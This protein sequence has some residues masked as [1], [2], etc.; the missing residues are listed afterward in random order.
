MNECKTLWN[1]LQT[2]LI[3]NISEDKPL[4]IKKTLQNPE[5]GQDL[6]LMW[7]WSNI[8]QDRDFNL[9]LYIASFSLH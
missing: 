2:L 7:L 8:S 9:T 6:W 5:F 3:I 4:L 1:I